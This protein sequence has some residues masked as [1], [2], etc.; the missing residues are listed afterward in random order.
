MGFCLGDRGIGR[1]ILRGFFV[2]ALEAGASVAIVK[3][4][5]G[6]HEALR[7]TFNLMY[8]NYTCFWFLATL[9]STPSEILIQT[10]EQWRVGVLRRATIHRLIRISLSLDELKGASTRDGI[11]VW[12]IRGI[13]GS[14]LAAI[15]TWAW[16]NLGGFFRLLLP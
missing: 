10:E 9:A 12:T 7:N 13:G 11:I 6:Q 16:A 14:A 2:G 1:G 3:S 4:P 8:I 5:V 15:F